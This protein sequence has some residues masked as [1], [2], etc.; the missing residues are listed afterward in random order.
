MKTH[1][2]CVIVMVFV[3]A[4]LAIG[5]GPSAEQAPSPRPAVVEPASYTLEIV[6]S[7]GGRIEPAPGKHEIAK[8]QKIRLAATPDR[9][10][11]FDYWDGPLPAVTDPFMAKA[12]FNLAKASR[13]VSWRGPSS[14]STT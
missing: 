7:P 14:V 10:Y 2:I 9:D 5:C 1:L 13:L 11:V 3:V 4:A 8:A 6:A 12:G